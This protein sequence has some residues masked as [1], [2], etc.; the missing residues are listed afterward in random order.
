[1]EAR[2]CWVCACWTCC[3]SCQGGVLCL[4]PPALA[5]LWRLLP[6]WPSMGVGG[7]AWCLAALPALTLWA[8]ALLLGCGCSSCPA[9]CGAA[10]PF[11][12]ASPLAAAF[13]SAGTVPA[14][15]TAR[16][17]AAPALAAAPGSRWTTTW[18]C[19]TCTRQ[20]QQQQQRQQQCC[21]ALRQALSRAPLALPSHPQAPLCRTCQ[22]ASQWPW[23]TA[24]RPLPP[25]QQ[26]SW[27][28]WPPLPP[29]TP[30]ACMW[31]L[32]RSA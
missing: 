3:A 17:C 16:Q 32:Q 15:S 7:A 28:P 18:R 8:P 21:G 2:P 6:A 11:C 1:M 29:F 20:R 27:L 19:S 25:Q 30:I 13:C 10:R 12:R 5:L 23:R 14:C 9:L 31:P 26:P 4:G 22:R 24:P